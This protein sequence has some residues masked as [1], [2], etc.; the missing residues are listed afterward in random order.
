MKIVVL[1]V[2]Y[3]YVYVYAYVYCNVVHV[4]VRVL[5]SVLPEVHVRVQY[6]VKFFQYSYI[7]SYYCSVLYT[8][9]CIKQLYCTV[10]SYVYSTRVHEC[11]SSGTVHVYTSVGLVAMSTRG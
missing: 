6:E 8:C 2:L 3:V 11:R 7:L 1:R 4:R 5:Y 9:T 10:K